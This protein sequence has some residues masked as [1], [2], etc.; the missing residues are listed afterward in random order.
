MFKTLLMTVGGLIFVGYEAGKLDQQFTEID[1]NASIPADKKDAY[2]ALA[3]IGAI[4]GAK[5]VGS[6]SD[7]ANNFATI[8]NKDPATKE[9][10]QQMLG[11]LPSKTPQEPNAYQQALSNFVNG[12]EKVIQIVLDYKWAVLNPLTLADAL[13]LSDWLPDWLVPAVGMH[14]GRGMV[15]FGSPLILDLDGDGAHSTKLGWGSDRSTVYF[16]MDNDGFAE[17]TGWVS[18]TDGL[19]AFDRNSNGK[20]DDQG[21]LFGN[22]ATYADGFASLKTLDSNADNKITAADAQFANLRVWVD[23]DRDGQTDAGELKAL[24]ALG[25]TQINLAAISLSH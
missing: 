18:K 20:I 13:G 5:T 24:A 8:A 25:I 10:I 1:N 16:D 23:A 6:P 12:L 7:A 3:L 21:E 4:P 19:L 9:S 22:S 11:N 2:K 14:G 17:R 15:N